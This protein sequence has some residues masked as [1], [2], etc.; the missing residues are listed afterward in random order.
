MRMNK[1]KT[2]IVKKHDGIMYLVI[3]DAIGLS[4]QWKQE[5]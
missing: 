1:E 3:I 4:Y 5:K 2:Y